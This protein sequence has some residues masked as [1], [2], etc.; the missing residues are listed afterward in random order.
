MGNSILLRTFDEESPHGLG[1]FDDSVQS[2][3]DRICDKETTFGAKK[4]QC[5]TQCR[6]RYRSGQ[7]FRRNLISGSK[8]QNRR[9]DLSTNCKIRFEESKSAQEIIFGIKRSNFRLEGP[10]VFTIKLYKISTSCVTCLTRKKIRTT[11]LRIRYD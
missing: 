2:R 9:L 8:D 1:R 11:Q 7:N 4:S 10:I 6:E 5:P 3:P